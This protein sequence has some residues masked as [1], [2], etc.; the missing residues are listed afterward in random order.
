[1]TEMWNAGLGYSFW[2]YGIGNPQYGN[3]TTGGNL[4]VGG[5]SWSPFCGRNLHRFFEVSEGDVVC[6]DTLL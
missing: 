3:W 2:I 5:E 4:T 1:M 6:Q